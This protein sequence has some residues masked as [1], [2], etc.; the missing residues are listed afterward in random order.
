MNV[1]SN[2]PLKELLAKLLFS[3]E[4]VS[5]EEQ[6]RMVNRACQ[7]AV[8][9]HEAQVKTMQ[10]WIKDMDEDIQMTNCVCPECH[11]GHRR[12]GHLKY[13]ALANMLTVIGKK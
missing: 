2:H 10:W 4:T 12:I 13:C 11:G 1:K 8:K 5:S 3:I 6:R 7:E 9:W